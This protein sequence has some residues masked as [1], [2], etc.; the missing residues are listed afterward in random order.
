MK[1]VKE[2]LLNMNNDD[3]DLIDK[4]DNLHG[5]GQISDYVGK[6]MQEEEKFEI[7]NDYIKEIL[8]G[9]A[10]ED[11]TGKYIDFIVEETNNLYEQGLCEKDDFSSGL[12]NCDELYLLVI[13]DVLDC[14][15]YNLE[16]LEEGYPTITI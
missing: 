7:A 5:H 14:D 11:L 6:L 16:N 13:A 4:L 3:I 10:H 12:Y 1:K 9:E 8:Y 15:F 2:F